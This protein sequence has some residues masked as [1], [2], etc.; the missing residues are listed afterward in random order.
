MSSPLMQQFLTGLKSPYADVRMKTAKSLYH[1]VKTEL[2]EVSAEE[3]TA[4]MDEFN[5]QIFEMVS[6]SNVNEKKG[7]I[8]AIGKFLYR[9]I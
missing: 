1:Y 5:H 6:G 8:L 9:V 4:F 7:G 3:L 2:R